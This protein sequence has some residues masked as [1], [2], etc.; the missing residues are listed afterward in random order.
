MAGA[1]LFSEKNFLALDRLQKLH[2]YDLK[3]KVNA[4]IMEKQMKHFFFLI[5]E[6]A[7]FKNKECLTIKSEFEYIFVHI[8]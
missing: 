2:F 3:S 7:N 8:Y 6:V 4:S 5:I 1:E